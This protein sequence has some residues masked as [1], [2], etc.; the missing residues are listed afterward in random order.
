MNSVGPNLAQV[1]PLPAKARPRTRAP[2]HAQT[3]Q[4]QPHL[5]E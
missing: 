3:L 2:T 4:E 5:L 1:G